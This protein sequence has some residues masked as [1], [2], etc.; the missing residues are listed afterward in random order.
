MEKYGMPMDA[1]DEKDANLRIEMIGCLKIYSPTR[2]P[3]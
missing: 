3:F 1:K 2:T